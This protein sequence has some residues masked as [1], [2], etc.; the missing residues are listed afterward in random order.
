MY[1]FR[2]VQVMGIPVPGLV[3]EFQPI[4]DY[5]A[6]QIAA[7][8]DSTDSRLQLLKDLGKLSPVIAHLKVMVATI[9]FD[10]CQSELESE[11]TEE[12]LKF[13]S[14]LSGP[15]YPI[16]ALAVATSGENESAEGT[17]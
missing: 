7:A 8:K 13:L 16:I 15:C 6:P 2:S 14:F 10:P 5:L 17:V 4:T 9:C 1:F 11:V 12:S 3:P